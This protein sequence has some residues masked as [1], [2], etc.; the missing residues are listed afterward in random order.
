MATRTSQPRN[1]V[2]SLDAPIYWLMKIPN[3]QATADYSAT[4]KD[5]TA[6]KFGDGFA[7]LESQIKMLNADGYV[8]G[9]NTRT[10]RTGRVPLN[11]LK[12]IIEQ[13]E[14]DF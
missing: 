13:L 5:D 2:E 3:F 1:A 10:G 14:F 7:L 8:R 11:K 4:S 6:L 12:T 9:T